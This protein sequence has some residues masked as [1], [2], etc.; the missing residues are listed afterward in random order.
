MS[1]RSDLDPQVL[2][3]STA[4]AARFY[5]D[6]AIAARERESI[7]L[8]HWQLVA[9]ISQLQDRGD[10]VVTEIA[11]VP[12][13]VL[14]DEAGQLRA[15]HNVC[16]HRAGPLARCDGRAAKVLRCAYHG[17]TYG[18]DGRLRAATE[19][20]DACDFN[21]ADRSMHAACRTGRRD[22]SA[23]RRP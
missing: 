15:F 19:M 11:G 3:S 12:I 6:A 23:A 5:T 4:L 10:H 14:R 13:I 21:V 7:F 1:P 20:Q 8:R 9:G 22:R 18:L 16:R 17:W 2:A